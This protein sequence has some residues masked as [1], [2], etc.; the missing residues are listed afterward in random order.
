MA[1]IRKHGPGR[2]LLL[3][4][5]S[6][7]TAITSYD[8]PIVR[9]CLFLGSLDTDQA[10]HRV[11]AVVSFISHTFGA[12]IDFL[13][14][15]SSALPLPVFVTLVYRVAVLY[16][17][18]RIIVAIKR[19]NSGFPEDGGPKHLSDEEPLARTMTIFVA[20]SRLILVRWDNFRVP[21]HH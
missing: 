18:L 3:F 20:Y 8:T 1:V 10:R 21:L 4:P 17:A 7:R 16:F 5:L 2:F 13:L 12:A 14:A 9:T 19:A 11:T 6:C 15:C